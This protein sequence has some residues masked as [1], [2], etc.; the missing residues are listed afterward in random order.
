MIPPDRIIEEE[1]ERLASVMSNNGNNNGNN[2][3]NLSVN[4]LSRL[5]S[6]EQQRIL[7]S[8]RSRGS[9]K[10]GGKIQKFSSK[11]LL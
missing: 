6:D 11:N 8:M 9:L 4:K 7:K 5:G 10:K 2:G 1:R 3:N